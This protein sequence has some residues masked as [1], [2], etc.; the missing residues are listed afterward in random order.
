LRHARSKMQDKITPQIEASVEAKR[1]LKGKDME[2]AAK[3]IS[4]AFKAKRKV[5][6]CGN[7]GSAADCQHIAGE[8][9]GKFR[10]ERAA[11]AAISLATDTSVLTA[12]ANDYGVDVVFS[13]QV[14]ALG[15]QGDV[16]MAFSTSGSSPN[17]LKAA[18]SAKARGMK[19]IG[20]TGGKGDKLKALSDVCM[21][22]AS[23]DT[24]RIQ[25]AHITAAHIICGLVEEALFG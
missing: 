24:P 5:L 10:K 18:I 22:V 6:L 23:T 16:L 4:D 12:L 15:T 9:V 20:F 7:G 2:A 21:M 1:S 25:E 13:R 8:F 17:I 11:L 14:E 3:L 19:V